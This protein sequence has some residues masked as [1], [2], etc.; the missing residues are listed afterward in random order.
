MFSIPSKQTKT[1]ELL[2]E[3]HEKDK[4]ED[5]Q[6]QQQQQPQR[7]VNLE[8]LANDRNN[9]VNNIGGNRKGLNMKKRRKQRMTKKRK[10]RE[11]QKNNRVDVGKSRWQTGNQ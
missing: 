8:K 4:N 1:G 2:T 6:Q 3:A 7:D 10:R 9:C 11:M 5:N